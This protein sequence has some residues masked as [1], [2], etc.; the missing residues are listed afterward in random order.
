MRASHRRGYLLC[1]GEV[2]I[3][4]EGPDGGGKTTLIK[5]LSERFDLPVAPRVVSQDAAAMVDLKEWVER[6]VAD[7]W[8][9][10]LFDR[11]RLISEPIYGSILRKTFE[12]GF[13]D[14]MWLYNMNY[15][16]FRNCRPLIIYCLPSYTVV[17]QNLD[18]DPDNVAV[19]HKIRRIYAQYVSRA[20]TDAV[21]AGAMIH[22][23][24]QPN[25]N[26]IFRVVQR[27]IE[28]ETHV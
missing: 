5:T 12:R 3:V 17:R 13:D 9:P 15:M 21:N 19:V 18:G 14:V 11:H 1:G 8:Q 10:T 23:Y 16:F 7:G 25:F 2:V 28:V 6:N 22:D 24:T 27:A 20:T 4:V 26:H